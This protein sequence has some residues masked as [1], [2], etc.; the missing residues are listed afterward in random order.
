M[1]KVKKG[2]EKRLSI[3]WKHRDR[4]TIGIGTILFAIFLIQILVSASRE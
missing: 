2:T 1:A 4:H 3:M